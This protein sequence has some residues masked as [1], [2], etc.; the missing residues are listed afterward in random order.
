MKKKMKSCLQRWQ[1][2]RSS[3]LQLPAMLAV[4]AVV[5]MMCACAVKTRVSDRDR[6]DAEKLVDRGALFLKVYN[7]EKATASFALSLEIAPNAAAMD[8]LGCAAMLQGDF[9][10]AEKY[11]KRAIELDQAYT[12]SLG[13]L[14]LLYEIRGYPRLAKDYY[15]QVLQASPRDSRVLQNYGAL[16]YD[17]GGGTETSRGLILQSEALRAHP[18]I[19]HNLAAYADE[20][21]RGP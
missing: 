14:A 5:F 7:Y 17:E 15:E 6:S 4:S 9:D 19:N 11:F 20:I 3:L 12:N 21:T 8:G 13:N 16:T 10:E 2:S 1:H 18:L